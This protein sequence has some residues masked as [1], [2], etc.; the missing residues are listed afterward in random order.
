MLAAGSWPFRLAILYSNLLFLHGGSEQEECNSFFRCLS[1]LFS[2]IQEREDDSPLYRSCLQLPKEEVRLL[3]PCDVG[4]LAD[5][6]DRRQAAQLLFDPLSGRRAGLICSQ[7]G[8][9]QRADRTLAFCP[10]RLGHSGVYPGLPLPRVLLVRG[11]RRHSLRGL[12]IGCIEAWC[13]HH[14][15]RVR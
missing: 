13:R 11:R 5:P 4:N 15:L 8:A 7:S 3:H 6:L 14:V 12:Q 2:R 10:S 1:M 9:C